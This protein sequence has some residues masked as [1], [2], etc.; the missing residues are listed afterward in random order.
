MENR[1]R[2]LMAVGLVC[3]LL[4]ALIPMSASAALPPRP[5]PSPEPSPSPSPEPT[6]EPPPIPGVTG[7]VILLRPDFPAYAEY[8]TMVQWLAGDGTWVDVDGWRGNFD[9]TG[10]VAWWVGADHLGEGPFRWLVFE[11]EGGDLLTMSDTFDLPASAG[12]M[13]IVEV[14]LEP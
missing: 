4:V 9:Q 5:S 14:L 12:R 6:E 2:I 13:V 8:W 10:V 7:G 3:L 1:Y 11:S